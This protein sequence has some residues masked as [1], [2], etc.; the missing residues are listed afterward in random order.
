M[1][2]RGEALRKLAGTAIVAST[3]AAILTVIFFGLSALSLETDDA[4]ALA[5]IRQAY[6][7]QSLFVD[8]WWMDGNTDVGAHQWNDCLILYQAVDRSGPSDKLWLSPRLYPN[9]S[10]QPC[11]YLADFAKNPSLVQPVEYYHR[12]VHGHTVAARFLLQVFSVAEIRRFYST[13]LAACV[14]AGFAQG[15]VSLGKGQREGWFWIITFAAFARWF[16]LESFGQSFSHGPADLVV[17]GML[18]FLANRS[19]A[20]GLD[21][22][23]VPMAAA[24][25]GSLTM[26]FEFLTGG[27][28]LGAAVLIGGLPFAVKPD[29]EDKNLH[30]IVV[31]GIIAF[32]IAAGTVLLI[33][34]LCVIAIFGP[35]SLAPARQQLLYYMGVAMPPASASDVR[36]GLGAFL[37]S[38]L[39][40]LHSLASGVGVMTLYMLCI[41]MAAGIWGFVTMMKVGD[42][43]GR[44]R[45]RALAASNLPLFG[46]LVLFWQHTAVHA[47]FMD[48]ILVWTI[49]SGMAL[50]VLA[51]IRGSATRRRSEV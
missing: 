4:K 30:S 25:F 17:V 37:R 5:S 12:Y 40:G 43:L 45:A 22:R 16:G 42:P 50:Y 15:L 36:A 38:L 2:T 47:R 9:S 23:H 34:T 24:I 49:V 26:I 35:E 20:G 51:V 33:K 6:A 10:A 1:P 39:I 3:I 48:R 31:R 27:L 8:R 19:A 7:E 29:A 21:S 13:L 32:A 41:S 46:W 11:T 28:P 18:L 14:M 44:T